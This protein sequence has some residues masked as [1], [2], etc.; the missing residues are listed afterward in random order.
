MAHCGMPNKPTI[1]IAHGQ[2]LIEHYF[3]PTTIKLSEQSSKSSRT[4]IYE[5]QKILLI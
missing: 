1:S 2:K 3:N 5:S 4:I